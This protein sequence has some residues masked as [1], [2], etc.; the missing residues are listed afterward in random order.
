MKFNLL[1][2]LKELKRISEDEYLECD[3]EKNHQTF[4]KALYLMLDYMSEQ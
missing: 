2:V 1:S 3:H 4:A